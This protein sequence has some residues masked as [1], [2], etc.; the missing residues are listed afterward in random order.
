MDRGYYLLKAYPDG[1][2]PTTN[3]SVAWKKHGGA[4]LAFVVSKKILKWDD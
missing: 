4:A 3:R 1:S 2:A